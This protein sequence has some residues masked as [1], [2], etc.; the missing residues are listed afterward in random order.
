MVAEPPPVAFA[1]VAGAVAHV[2]TPALDD[3]VLIDGE[4]GHHLQRVRRLR[5]GERV[6]VSDGRGGW[7]PYEITH[8]DRGSLVLAPA[9]AVH[10]EPRLNPTLAVA[11]GLSK[12]G[13]PEHVV[14]ALTELGADRI[15]PFRSARS[16]VRWEGERA[17]SATRR[18][19]RVAREAAMQ[20][21]RARLPEVSEP[22]DVSE[23]ATAGVLVVGEP[24]GRPVAEVPFAAGEE[25]LVVVGAEGGL[26]PAERETLARQPRVVPVAIGPHVLR[27]ETAAVSL[28][29]ALAGRRLV[30]I[31]H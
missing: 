9:G 14:A 6:T 4:D 13:K 11:F 10:R 23:L 1:S 2:F 25:W 20:C 8:S 16:V 21:R 31:G 30:A 18:L 26:D 7:R 24:A 3:H 22:V 17:Q 28:A 29:A 27:A 12:G 19:R 15:V 5:A